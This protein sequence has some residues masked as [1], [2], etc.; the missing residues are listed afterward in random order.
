MVVTI[1]NDSESLSVPILWCF[2]LDFCVLYVFFG[3][4]GAGDKSKTSKRPK[5]QNMIDNYT[6]S[7]P[8]LESHSQG[9]QQNNGQPL[10]QLP[11]PTDGHPNSTVSNNPPI[12]WADV[13]FVPP[14]KRSRLTWDNVATAALMDC[15]LE[16]WTYCQT[17]DNQHSASTSGE[18]HYVRELMAV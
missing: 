5:I 17:H 13:S 8:D 3:I 11:Q 2:M 14:T 1:E 18:G 16:Y 7:K 12:N 15:L 9:S 6:N 4:A 10:A